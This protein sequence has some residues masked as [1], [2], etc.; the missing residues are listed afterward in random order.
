MSYTEEEKMKILKLLI[1]RGKNNIKMV[2]DGDSL[3][4]ATG[5]RYPKTLELPIKAAG[6]GDDYSLLSLHFFIDHADIRHQDYLFL[7]T[8]QSIP[9][10]RFSD[11]RDLLK[12]LRGTSDAWYDVKLDL[13]DLSSLEDLVKTEAFLEEPKTSSSAAISSTTLP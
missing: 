11:R 4:M 6:N 1:A 2:V 5:L 8:E 12:L 13:S 3:V 10:V 7:C 9:I